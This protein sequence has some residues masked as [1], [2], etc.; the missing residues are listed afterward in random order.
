MPELRDADLI[1]Q[2]NYTHGSAEEANQ[3]IA[4]ARTLLQGA[5][6]SPPP[7]ENQKQQVESIT[8]SYVSLLYSV[9][10][11]FPPSTERIALI[12]GIEASKMLAVN[13]IFRTVK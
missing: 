9:L 5:L 10:A 6:H 2:T 13:T 12:Q 1:Y 8:N 4:D 11:T 3:I 7:T